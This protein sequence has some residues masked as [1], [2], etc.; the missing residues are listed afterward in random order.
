MAIC[1]LAS[2][3]WPGVSSTWPGTPDY[4]RQFN[5]WADRWEAAARGANAKCICLRQEPPGTTPDRDRLATVLRDVPKQAESPLWLVLV[6]HG[7][8]D[9]RK[10][11]FNLF[12]P[13]VTGSELA[14]WLQ[15]FERPLVVINCAS[16]SAPFINRLSGANRV[17][18]SAT[19]S[20]Y[21]LNVA[22]FGDHLSAAITQVSAP[23]RIYGLHGHNQLPINEAKEAFEKEYLLELL[24]HHDYNV[25][26]A[27]RTAG[28]HRQSLHRLMRK[29]DIRTNERTSEVPAERRTGGITG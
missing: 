27:A 23:T 13:D 9:G 28:V 15:P 10:A 29:H 4:E 21:E 2:Q 17:I 26:A 16:S 14:A 1:A 18:I 25:T 24:R 19:K 22:R 7:T 3:R 11:K 20:G 12:G 5:A 8:F 6:G